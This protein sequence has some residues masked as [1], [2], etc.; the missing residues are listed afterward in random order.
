MIAQTL[1]LSDAK[2]LGE[3][4]ITPTGAPNRGGVISKS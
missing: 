3:I 1:K 2:N 4:P